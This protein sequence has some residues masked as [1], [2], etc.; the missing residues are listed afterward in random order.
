[1]ELIVAVAAIVVFVEL[2]SAII[3]LFVAIASAIELFVVLATLVVFVELFVV[4]ASAIELFAAL[5]SAIE[6][7]VV[8]ASAIDLLAVLASAIELCFVTKEV[9]LSLEFVVLAVDDDSL[10]AS[11]ELGISPSCGRPDGGTYLQL[12]YLAC[13]KAFHT[14]LLYGCHSTGNNLCGFANP[15]Q[16]APQMRA[17]FIFSS[18]PSGAIPVLVVCQKVKHVL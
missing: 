14:A 4:I 9:E 3:E 2:V 8:L 1:M 15:L 11:E 5:A 17:D 7:F 10:A 13:C 12:L 18:C 16:H 6:L